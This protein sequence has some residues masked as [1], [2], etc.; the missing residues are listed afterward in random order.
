MAQTKM[1]EIW[2]WQWWR[3]WRVFGL[4]MSERGNAT[5][6]KQLAYECECVLKIERLSCGATKLAGLTC[7]WHGRS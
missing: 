7:V 3:W 1:E 2:W 6:C 5:C 4:G